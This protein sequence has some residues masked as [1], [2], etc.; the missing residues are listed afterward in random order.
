MRS[1]A[2]KRRAVMTLLGDPESR[3][4]SDRE[5]ARRCQV[6]QPFVSKLRAAHA[7]SG[8]PE[9]DQHVAVRGG[10]RYLIHAADINAGRRG[11]T[12]R[13]VRPLDEPVVHDELGQLVPLPAALTFELWRR[14]LGAIVTQLQAAAEEWR[15]LKAE[16]RAC[17]RRAP[18]AKALLEKATRE[19]AE[20]EH[21]AKLIQGSLPYAVCPHCDGH[22][23]AYCA[24][25]RG[26]GWVDGFG[27]DVVRDDLRHIARSV[28]QLN[29][30]RG[31]G[32][33]LPA[34]RLP[35]RK[36]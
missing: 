20:L 13:R 18:A 17:G 6:S 33:V 8:G 12:R 26:V 14:R 27:F 30:Y 31:E 29:R 28:G 11:K 35:R 5:I 23:A 10:Q 1:A 34:R 15:Q 3:Q 19:S 32:F 22:G 9:P 2:D 24:G 16:L 4:W 36:R 21:R 25:C 7:A